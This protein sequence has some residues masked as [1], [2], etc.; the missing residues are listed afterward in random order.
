[1]ALCYWGLCDCPSRSPQNP[2]TQH[3]KFNCSILNGQPITDEAQIVDGITQGVDAEIAALDDEK[4][5]VENNKAALVQRKLRLEQEQRQLEAQFNSASGIGDRRRVIRRARRVL[6]QAKQERQRLR[7]EIDDTRA[8]I[9][10]P[11]AAVDIARTRLRIPYRDPAGDCACHTRKQ[12]R[13]DTLA[14]QLVMWDIELANVKGLLQATLG[15]S[16]TAWTAAIVPI[17]GL[18]AALIAIV[19]FGVGFAALILPV[20]AF[21]L[22]VIVIMTLQLRLYDL[23]N[24]MIDIKRIIAVIVLTYYRVQQ[25]PVCQIATPEQEDGYDEWWEWWKP[26]F[27]APPELPDESSATEGSGN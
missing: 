23:S 9:D 21:I 17:I 7:Q 5:T 1:M 4:Q 20:V 25:V 24:R 16:Q 15:A 12:D 26:W 18:F 6:Q 3:T 13:L 11:S 19:W 27:F 14:A 8:I 22:V 2:C 10:R